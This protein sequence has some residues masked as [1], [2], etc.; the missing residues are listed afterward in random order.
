MTVQYPWHPLFGLKLRLVK[1]AKTTGVEELHCEL[2]EGIVLGIPRWM[3]DAGRCFSMEVGE[4]VVE[5]GALG[6]CVPC[7]MV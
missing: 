5:V 6:N 2:P 3:T 4:P 7:S 1:I